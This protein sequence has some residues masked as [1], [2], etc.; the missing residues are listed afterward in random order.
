LKLLP[1]LKKRCRKASSPDQ[2][3]VINNGVRLE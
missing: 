3:T 2:N 1:P